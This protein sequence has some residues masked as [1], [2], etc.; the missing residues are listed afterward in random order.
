MPNDTKASY[1]VLFATDLSDG[2]SIV[3]NYA[4]GLASVYQAKL[5]LVHVLDPA[6]QGN[7][8]D[9]SAS[10]LRQLAQSA[11]LELERISQ[12]LLAAHGITGE[13]VVRYGSIR[14]VIFQV[15]QESAAQLVVMGSSGKKKGAASGKTLGSVAEAVLRSLP[16][17]VLIVGPR[18]GLRPFSEKAEAVVFTTDFSPISLAALPV[19]ASFSA[20][21]SA[22]L[23]LLHV[24]DSHDMHTGFED[25]LKN[26]E[27]LKILAQ[28]VETK[29]GQVKYF[30]EGGEVA[31][32]ALSFAREHNADFIAMGAHHGDLD[33][34]TRLHGIVSDIV[35]EAHCPVITIAEATIAASQARAAGRA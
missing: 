26:R 1:A 21:L 6:S 2:S 8:M 10:D 5:V 30:I 35:R 19:A 33:D 29:P 4:A 25:E 11:K 31:Q 3:L 34:G 18:V 9:S 28:S 17:S 15:Q 14:D 32:S 24:R 20:R 16:C 27:K 7:S 13:V 22:N 12:S 23:L